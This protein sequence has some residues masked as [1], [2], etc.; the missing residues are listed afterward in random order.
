MLPDPQDPETGVAEEMH[1][2]YDAFVSYSE[3]YDEDFVY[4]LLE[5]EFVCCSACFNLHFFY[6]DKCQMLTSNAPH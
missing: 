3:G 2:V 4:K 5:V 6:F 1:Y